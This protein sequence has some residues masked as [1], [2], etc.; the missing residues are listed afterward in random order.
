MLMVDVRA[1]DDLHAVSLSNRRYL[2]PRLHHEV[3]RRGVTRRTDFGIVCTEQYENH[4]DSPRFESI[5]DATHS[6]LQVQRWSAVRVG[7]NGAPNSS[8]AK[9]TV[10][11][12]ES[13]RALSG[14][15]RS[16]RRPAPP[17]PGGKL[18]DRQRPSHR[19]S[20]PA[21]ARAGQLRA[22]RAT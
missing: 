7:V 17:P 20:A 1:S 15:S 3:A 6:A 4:A 8:T 18:A 14:P 12:S 16:F 2:S 21:V 11:R 13:S 5:T 19:Q 9:P 10:P 22:D